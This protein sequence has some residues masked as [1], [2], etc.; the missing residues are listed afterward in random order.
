MFAELLATI[1]MG[2]NELMPEPGQMKKW[3]GGAIWDVTVRD[4]SL[5]ISCEQTKCQIHIDL[6]LLIDNFKHLLFDNGRVAVSTFP[7]SLFT[8]ETVKGS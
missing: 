4:Y 2:K 8:L 1:S 7:V 6:S 3:G 5:N